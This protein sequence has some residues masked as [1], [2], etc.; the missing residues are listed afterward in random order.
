MYKDN[1]E[2]RRYRTN[3]E[4][5]MP[6]DLIPLYIES[7]NEKEGLIEPVLKGETDSGYEKVLLY[8]LPDINRYV[9]VLKEPNG[10]GWSID[11]L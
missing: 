4:H 3:L 2:G 11:Y 5:P 10:L 9:H 6:A 1:I 7:T 8:L